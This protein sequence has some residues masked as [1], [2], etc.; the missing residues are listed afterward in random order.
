MMTATEEIRLEKRQV[1]FINKEIR[2]AF[3]E[4]IIEQI[5][6]VR[7]KM[8]RYKEICEDLRREKDTLVEPPPKPRTCALEDSNV[9]AI[10]AVINVELLLGRPPAY[11]EV[12]VYNKELVNT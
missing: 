11:H 9:A 7:N 3:P 2:I 6:G 1:K 8:D 5:K 4:Y 12:I 10:K